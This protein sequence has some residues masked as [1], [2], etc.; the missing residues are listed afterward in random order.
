MVINPRYLGR[1]IQGLSG[2]FI[3]FKA[4]LGNLVRPC[5]KIKHQKIKHQKSSGDLEQLSGTDICEA[6]VSIPNTAN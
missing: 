5:I 1:L 3:K 6:L 4:S 2:V